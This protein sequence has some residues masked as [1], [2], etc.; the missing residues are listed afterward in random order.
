MDRKVFHISFMDVRWHR[1]S[2]FLM[3]SRQSR[4]MRGWRQSEWYLLQFSCVV[5]LMLTWMHCVSILTPF[6]AYCSLY[7]VCNNVQ[8]YTHMQLH[9][10]NTEYYSVSQKNPAPEVFWHFS[11]NGWEFLDQILCTCYTFLS[12]LITNF[13]P[14]IC[15]FDEVMP[16]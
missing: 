1:R 12:T 4:S 9:V 8:H 6:H 14:I 5:T 10:L 11:P 16:Y 7:F 15:N 2:D 3:C 13:Y